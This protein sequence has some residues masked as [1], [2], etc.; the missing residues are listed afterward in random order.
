M[1]IGIHLGLHYNAIVKLKKE[2]KIILNVFLSLFAVVFG[3]N[4]FL[5]KEFIEKITLQSLYPLYSEDNIVMFLIDYI[6][7]LIMFVMIGYVILNL[8]KIKKKEKTE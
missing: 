4:G 6:G 1:L 3:I 7:I 2:N 5:K 8:M